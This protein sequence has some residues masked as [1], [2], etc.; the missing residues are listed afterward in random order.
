VW[1]AANPATMIS[2]IADSAPPASMTSARPCRI[3]SYPAMI[4]SCPEADAPLTVISGPRRPNR[5]DSKEVAA[6]GRVWLNSQ[7]VTPRVPFSARTASCRASTSVLENATPTAAP[8]RSNPT[9]L[10][11]L[12]VISRWARYSPASASAS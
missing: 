9:S 2:V 10:F 7:G 5:T 4:E 6:L 3:L 11:F 1:F 8:N 12:D